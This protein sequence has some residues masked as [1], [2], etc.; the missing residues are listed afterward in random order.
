MK[1]IYFL[2]SREVLFAYIVH[3]I[4]F[5]SRAKWY[6]R[7][8]NIDF[9][10]PDHFKSAD[11]NIYLH[12]L[13]GDTIFLDPYKWAVKECMSSLEFTHKCAFIHALIPLFFYF[14]YTLYREVNLWF[15]FRHVVYLCWAQIW[16]RNL[17]H[18]IVQIWLISL[19]E[20]IHT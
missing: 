7:K 19:F 10:L 3:I 6:L 4:S 15:I 8:F 20:D 11:M 18:D 13:S 2:V 5:E 16:F 1:Q 9:I 14:V 12:R 17:L